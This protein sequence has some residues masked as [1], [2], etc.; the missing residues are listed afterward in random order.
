MILVKFMF[1]IIQKQNMLV[2]QL[3]VSF[4]FLAFRIFCGSLCY[5]ALTTCSMTKTKQK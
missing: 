1:H 5:G 3:F 4:S 2:W